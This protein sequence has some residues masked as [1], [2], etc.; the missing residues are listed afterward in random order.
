MKPSIKDVFDFW[1]SNPCAHETSNSKDRLDYFLGIEKYRYETIPFIKKIGR[2]DEFNG[3]VV[4]EIGCGLGTDGAQFAKGGAH[5]LGVDLTNAAVALAQENFHLQGL[6]GEFSQVNAED[7]PFGTA[8]I[9]HI[10]FLSG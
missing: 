7:L 1:D 3:R 10:S 2:F 9:D 5:Y 4:L 8:T 6:R